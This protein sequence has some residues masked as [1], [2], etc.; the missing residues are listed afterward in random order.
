MLFVGG[1]ARARN[2]GDASNVG[3]RHCLPWRSRA[4]LQIEPPNGTRGFAALS[5]EQNIS[6]LHPAQRRIAGLRAAH[7]LRIAAISR[8]QGYSIVADNCDSLAIRGDRMRIQC[9]AEALRSN[10]TRLS[11]IETHNIHARAMA[12]L[13]ALKNNSL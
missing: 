11:T 13:V 2:P 5:H 10:G 6:V 1:Q 3:W 8:N 9:Q 4:G 7:R 12:R